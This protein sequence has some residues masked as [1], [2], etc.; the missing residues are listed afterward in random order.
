VNLAL[1]LDSLSAK[2]AHTTGEIAEDA[3]LLARGGIRRAGLI[4]LRVDI[5]HLRRNTVLESGH[6]ITCHLA[7]FINVAPACDTT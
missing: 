1:V 7:F 2:E 6:F 5:D 4:S 3:S